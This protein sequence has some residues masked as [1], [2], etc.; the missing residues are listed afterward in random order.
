MNSAELSS[1]I[2]NYEL[3]KDSKVNY[4]L[5]NGRY[6]TI[7]LDNIFWDKHYLKLWKYPIVDWSKILKFRK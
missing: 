4:R 2:I 5:L 6:G 3:R 1:E 7:S